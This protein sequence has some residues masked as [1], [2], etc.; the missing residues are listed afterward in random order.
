MLRRFLLQ[1]EFCSVA[2]DAFRFGFGPKAGPAPNIKNFQKQ[3]IQA[4]A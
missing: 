2:I 1:N 4:F 3:R